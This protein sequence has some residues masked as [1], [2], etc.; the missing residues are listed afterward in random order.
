M[1]FLSGVV[2][3]LVVGWFLLPQPESVGK[4]V[5]KIKDKLRSR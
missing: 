1:G 5:Q 2:F 3:G 4:L